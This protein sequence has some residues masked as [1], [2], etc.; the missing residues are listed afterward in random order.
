[1]KGFVVVCKIGQRAG[2]IGI[3]LE[4]GTTDRW[5]NCIL[6]CSKIFLA[7][8]ILCAPTYPVKLNRFACLDYP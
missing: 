5:K 8:E 3:E 4:F 2:I 6:S 7:L 1:V